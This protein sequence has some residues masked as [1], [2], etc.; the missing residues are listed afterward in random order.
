MSTTY[1][2]LPWT[3]Q[4][5]VTAVQDEDQDGAD[6]QAHATFPI[7]LDVNDTPNDAVHLRLYG[8]GDIVA[9][10]RRQI[11]RTEPQDRS[12]DFPPNYFAAIEFDRP[13]FPWLFTPAKAERT[14]SRLRPWLCLVVVR[15]QDGVTLGSQGGGAL[16]VL[17]IAYP[18]VPNHELPDLS[19]SWA[20]AHS[21]VVHNGSTLDDTL[22]T[23]PNQN[24]SRLLCPRHLNPHANYYACL[25]PAFEVGRQAGLVDESKPNGSEPNGSET[26]TDANRLQPAWISGED[27]PTQ[28]RLPVYFHW[29][30]RTSQ[31][32]DFEALAQLLRPNILGPGEG[33]RKLYVDTP[34]DVQYTVDFA[35]VFRPT[36]FDPALL[37]DQDERQDLPEGQQTWLAQMEEALNYADDLVTRDGLDSSDPDPIV[38]PPIY[39]RFH[40]GMQRLSSGLGWANDLNL[41]ARN[42]SAAGLGTVFVQAHQEELMHSAW[43][44]LGDIQLA[45]QLTRQNEVAEIVSE[46]TFAK[47]FVPLQEAQ[48]SLLYQM[49][50]PVHA[51]VQLGEQ[52]LSDWSQQQQFPSAETLTTF[53]KVSR[54]QGPISQRLQSQEH[55]TQPL[56]LQV[57]Q[58]GTDLPHALRVN[59]LGI[60]LDDISQQ[61]VHQVRA[62]D[63][64][65]AVHLQE[66]FTALRTRLEASSGSVPIEPRVA[67]S[68]ANP[69]ESLVQQLDPKVTIPRILANRVQQSGAVSPEDRTPGFIPLDD[70]AP[71]E[72]TS[73][74]TY[75]VFPQPMYEVIREL[76]PELLLPGADEIPNNTVTLLETNPQFIEAFMTGL[77]QEMSRELLWRQFPTDQRGTYFR[78]FWNE[79]QIDLEELHRWQTGDR[80]G[81]HFADGQVAGD[82]VLV[83][84]G[85]LLRRFPNTV[86]YAVPATSPTTMAESHHHPIH[87]GLLSNDTVFL[88]F[89]D[90]TDQQALGQ[91]EYQGHSEGCFFVFQEQPTEPRFGLDETLGPSAPAGWDDLAW[92]HVTTT[93]GGYL[94]VQ[95]TE[96]TL[97]PNY[98]GGLWNFNSAHMACITLQKPFRVAFHAKRLVLQTP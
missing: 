46:A 80:L 34:G 76:M 71:D 72:D 95:A 67:K 91:A 70:T 68:L 54:S 7:K 77:N 6:L 23:Q 65:A 44:Q 55:L 14:K 83:I 30:F 20:W 78:S 29:E 79:G 1:S 74:R 28:I 32:G 4:G 5:A 60:I 87:R 12:N 21:Q 66:A 50:S 52:T 62:P 31:T 39:G 18:A 40:Q 51:R 53:R 56:D 96:D 92:R 36:A 63:R 85:E 61:M 86:I 16:P 48:S 59:P 89:Q 24:A 57:A 47:H 22:N 17:T 2:F 93:D 11:I 13:D 42:R 98:P 10:D 73:P 45:Q 9:I 43:Q 15:K 8:P 82:L 37:P 64:L 33:S 58:A 97:N 49:T 88:L 75:P 26:E 19:E 94:Q 81:S 38:G 27:A 69:V 90:L 25:V 35:G 84:R 3:R 41:D